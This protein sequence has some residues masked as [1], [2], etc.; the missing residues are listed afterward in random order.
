MKKIDNAV[1]IPTSINGKL[2]KY[3]FEFLAPLHRLSNREMDVIACLTKH[4]YELSKAIKDAKV[5]D[6]VAFS[7]ETKKKVRDECHVTQAHFNAIITKLKKNR[8][9][10]DGK[11]NPKFIPNISEDGNSLSLLL[12]FD[13]N[14]P[15]RNNL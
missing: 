1:R 4:R 14:E 12:F 5:L 13:L 11:I 3:W 7:E 2:F 6:E 8:V 9:I 15:T 10:I